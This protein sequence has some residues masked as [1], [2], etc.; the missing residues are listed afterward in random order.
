[1]SHLLIERNVGLFMGIIQISVVVLYDLEH[2]CR[3]DFYIWSGGQ[4][5]GFPI[6]KRTGIIQQVQTD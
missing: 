4:I 5:V 1:M 6:T 2:R 3:E